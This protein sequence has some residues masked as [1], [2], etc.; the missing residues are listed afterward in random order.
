MNANVFYVRL[1]F[2]HYLFVSKVEDKNYETKPVV[3]K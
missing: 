3:V 1:T 2:G